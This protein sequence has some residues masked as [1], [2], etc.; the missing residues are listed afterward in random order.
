M[1]MCPARGG[2]FVV[3]ALVV[4]LS[5]A[6]SSGQHARSGG[7]ARVSTTLV[8]RPSTSTTASPTTTTT[9]RPRAAAQFHPVSAS[10]VSARDGWVLEV[11]GSCDPPEPPCTYRVLVTIDGGRT[12]VRLVDLANVP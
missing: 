5:G 12:W 2:W 9:T 11:S 4:A 7:S 10:F 1:M 8:A 6:C 3:A